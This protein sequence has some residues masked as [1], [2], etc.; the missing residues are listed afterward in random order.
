LVLVNK[1][2]IRLLLDKALIR[3]KR[4]ENGD[5]KA[6]RRLRKALTASAT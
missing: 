4:V 6:L 2:L 5:N 3:L 1:A